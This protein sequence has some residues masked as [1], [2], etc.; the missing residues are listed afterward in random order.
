MG[1][2]VCTSIT[3]DKGNG[4]LTNAEGRVGER[5]AEGVW[6]R[7]SA[8]CDDSGAVNE[9]QAGITIFAGPKN[10]VPTCWHARGYGL[11]AANPFGRQK[12]GFPAM[13]DNSKL[14][15]LARGERLDLRYGLFLHLGDV[16][17]GQVA[18]YYDRFTKLK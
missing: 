10:P 18:D 2:R 11:L 1:V 17:E 15:R 16:K 9:R 14:V 4:K 6:G 12:S 8:W 13:K 7:I 5:G 3:E